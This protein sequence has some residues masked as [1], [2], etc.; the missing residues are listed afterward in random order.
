MAF[1]SENGGHYNN[2]YTA[3]EAELVDKAKR[4][5]RG[6]TA[7]AQRALKVLTNLAQGYRV[8]LAPSTVWLHV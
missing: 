1:P 8:M 5:H 2:H 7:S 6:T 3:D 4:V